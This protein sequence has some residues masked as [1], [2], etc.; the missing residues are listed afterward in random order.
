MLFSLML[1]TISQNFIAGPQYLEMYI[2]LHNT[3]YVILFCFKFQ[4][5]IN[6]YKCKI[7]RDLQTY[8]RYA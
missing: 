4:H 2:M 3:D 5:I 7:K 8:T 1:V 6:H